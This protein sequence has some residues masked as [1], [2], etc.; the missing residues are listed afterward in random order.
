MIMPSGTTEP[1]DVECVSRKDLAAYLDRHPIV[2]E[3]DP[4]IR[5]IPTK[6]HE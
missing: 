1:A 4:R 6:E 2:P 3:R 5:I